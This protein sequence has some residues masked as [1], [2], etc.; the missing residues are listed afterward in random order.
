MLEILFVIFFLSIN[1]PCSAMPMEMQL[2]QLLE[3]VP[4]SPFHSNGLS[5]AVGYIKKQSSGLNSSVSCQEVVGCPEATR[6]VVLQLKVI[7]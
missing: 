6:K 7:Y 5:K 2:N 3:D 4:K 1:I